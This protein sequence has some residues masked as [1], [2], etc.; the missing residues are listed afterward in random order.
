MQRRTGPRRGRRPS[1]RRW[2]RRQGRECARRHRSCRPPAWRQAARGVCA[3][4]SGLRTSRSARRARQ[5]RTRTE[6][7]A[8]GLRRAMR[9]RRRAWRSPGRDKHRQADR[10][11]SRGPAA[12]RS[13]FLNPAV[14]SRQ[15]QRRAT[16]RA[17]SRHRRRRNNRRIRIP[18]RTGR[19]SCRCDGPSPDCAAPCRHRRRRRRSRKESRPPSIASRAER[20][21]KAPSD[22]LIRTGR[23]A[24]RDGAPRRGI[25]PR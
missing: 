17:C 14:R 7:R 5:R 11:R 25:L 9:R 13:A 20:D 19:A 1:N 12:P 18:A 16:G 23:P 3:G 24:R 6:C 21:R 2:R 15:P 22:I 8:C 10:S 4:R